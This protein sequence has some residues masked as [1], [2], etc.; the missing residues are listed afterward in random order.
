MFCGAVAISVPY[1]VIEGLQI[2][3]LGLIGRV[4]HYEGLG[5]RLDFGSA[6]AEAEGAVDKAV[7]SAAAL[8]TLHSTMPNA[9]GE[10]AQANPSFVIIRAWE[11]LS[12]ALDDLRGVTQPERRS[13]R[14]GRIPRELIES[15]VFTQDFARAVEEL[16]GLRNR[17]AHGESN[18]TPGEAAAYAGSAA[19][20]TN[21][22][23]NL[24]ELISNPPLQ[25]EQSHT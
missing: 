12:A 17:V 5:Q 16:R 9:L 22:A 3:S 15:G 2:G 20:L 19:A 11:Q 18:P 23:R 1:P 25:A 7:E 21:Y 14:N 13:V 8:R 24:V 10:A 6:L 4:T